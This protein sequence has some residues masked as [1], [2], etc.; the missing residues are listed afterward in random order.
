MSE[1]L[2]T[3]Q[4]EEDKSGISVVTVNRPGQLNAINRQLFRE[5]DD[6]LDRFSKQEVT[7]G[8]ILTGA[9]EKAFVAGADIK[10]LEGLDET[11]ARELSLEGQ[12][13]FR[14]LEQLPIPVIAAVNGYA[15]GG[16]LEL[17]M[18]CHL[19]VASETA[20]LGMPETGLGLI[21]GYGG[22]QR[23][24]RL[25]GSGLALEMILTGRKL[26]AEEALEA[27]LVNRV[28]R[29]EAVVD[30]AISLL[31]KILDKGPQVIPAV[32]KAVRESGLPGGFET[33][34]TLFGRLCDSDDG[35][36]GIRAFIEKRK[37]NF[38]KR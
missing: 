11:A 38:S 14:K 37:P 2:E 17:A 8:V 18:A 33:E 16:G 25:V 7:R 4:L 12:R 24:P 34:A 15:L 10:E 29:Q 9:G 3:V 6:L 32:L 36:E 5:L 35:R 21:P 30:G 22:T 31:Q 13:V 1:Y 26:T 20:V 27:G 28:I 19:R 23:L